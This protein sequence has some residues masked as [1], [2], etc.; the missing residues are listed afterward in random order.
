MSRKHFQALADEISY[1]SDALARKFAAQAVANACARSNNRFDYS[2]FY[3]ACGV[4][5]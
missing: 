4:E 2:R 1:I 3:A 5:L